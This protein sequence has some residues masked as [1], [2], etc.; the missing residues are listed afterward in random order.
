MSRAADALQARAEILKLARILEREPDQLVYLEQLSL[1]DLRTLRERIT[2]YL[3]SA[4]GSM[5][6]RLA[7]ASRLLPTAV[8]AAISERAFGPVLSARMAGLVEPARAVD[9]AGRLSPSFLADVA[10]ELDPRRANAMIA[11]IAPDQ[12]GLVTRELL[13]REEYVT[14]GRFVGH[15]QDD[16]II[17]AVQEMQ[18]GELLRVAFVLEEKARLDR[19]VEL[20]PE[21]RLVAIVQ[22]ASDEGLWVEALDLLEN[23]GAERR[24]EL[25]AGAVAL[26]GA[27]LEGL[28]AAVIEHELW[29]EVLVIAE[30]DPALQGHLAE[31][32]SALPTDQRRAVARRAG[33]AGAIERLGPLGEALSAQGV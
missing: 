16:A 25:V 9:I 29:E 6:G 2:E 17:A 33:E 3:W 7:A 30:R 4:H 14:M 8:S 24:D 28:I 13:A 12:I 18:E 32:L 22:A 1:T 10:V 21:H 5:L 26:D 23:L 19:L 31:R 11:G 27:A 20:L 15:L